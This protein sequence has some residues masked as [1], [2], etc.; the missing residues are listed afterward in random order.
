MMMM[1]IIII[2]IILEITNYKL[3]YD[4]SVIDEICPYH[5]SDIVIVDTSVKEAYSVDVTIP[6]NQ[7]LHSTF[8]ERRHMYTDVKEHLIRL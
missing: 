8:T 2:I 6:N 4:R 5:R 3:K 1:M 7:N